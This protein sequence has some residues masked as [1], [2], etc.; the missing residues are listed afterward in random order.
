MYLFIMQ[1]QIYLL[2]IYL[3]ITYLFIMQ[4]QLANESN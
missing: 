4:Q 2:C 3:C 1:Q